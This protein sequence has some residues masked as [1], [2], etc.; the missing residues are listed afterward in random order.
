MTL[1][2]SYFFSF[3]GHVLIKTHVPSAQEE[4]MPCAWAMAQGQRHTQCSPGSF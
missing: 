1:A 4:V 3:K 2:T